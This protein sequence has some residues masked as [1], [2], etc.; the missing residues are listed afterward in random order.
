MLPH[1]GQRIREQIERNRQAT[2]CRSHHGLVD[3]ERVAM[4]DENG[5]DL[6]LY[7]TRADATLPATGMKTVAII[8]AGDIG[9]ATAQALAAH[10]HVGRVLLVDTRQDAAAGKALDI[11]QAG[12]IDGFHTRLFGTS[13]ETRVMGCSVC[14]I[15]DR[16]GD[17][18]GEWRD[19]DGLAMLTRVER[20]LGDAPIVFAGP[21][22][23]ELMAKAARELSIARHRLIGSSP[24]ALASSI[25]AIVAL[26]ARC[27]PR[28]VALTVLGR[29]P[30]G[31]VVPWS[32]ASIGGHA[33][34]AV[35]SQAQVGRIEAR[36]SRLW[37]PGPN[38]LGAAA[39]VVTEGILSAS[40]R[41]FNVLAWLDGEFGVRRVV[42]TL[43]VRLS[44]DGIVDIRVPSLGSRE[45]TQIQTAL[46]A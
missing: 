31:F 18:P 6:A 46:N 9:G 20:Y 29:P 13:D 45:Q 5:H 28:E 4:F 26:E 3:L 1:H 42:G 32:E 12:A 27:S 37:P 19:D 23:V 25:T 33:L 30:A 39:A 21:R 11:Q 2:T 34:S 15:A 38:T 16:L 40:R 41:S 36:V 24:E 7:N 43:P 22:Q 17:A 35:L 8:G 14:V 10:G 44:E